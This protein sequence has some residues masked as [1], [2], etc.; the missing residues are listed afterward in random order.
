VYTSN[1]ELAS[2]CVAFVQIVPAVRVSF[3]R[4]VRL[5]SFGNESS[6]SVMLVQAVKIETE[7][8]EK[9]ISKLLVQAVIV[10]HSR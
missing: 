2:R 9:N 4:V 1:S 8:S 3:T 6:V 5:F 7:P 10:S